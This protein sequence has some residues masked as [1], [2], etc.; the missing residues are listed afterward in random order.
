MCARFTL[1]A[2]P[3]LLAERFNLLQIPQLVAR[4]NIAPSQLL[5]V[6]GTK[7]GS[8]AR[9]LAMFKW[10][11]IPNWAQDDK[12]MRPVNARSESIAGSVMFG[13]SFRKRRCIVPADGFYEWRTEGKRKLPVHFRLM[14]GSPFAFAGIGD[15]WKGPSGSV[16]TYAIL[17]TKPN[18]LTATVH[19]RMPV[20]LAREDEAAWLDP[21]L[22]DATKLLPLLR[23]FPAA[24]MEAVAANP[25]MN[26]PQ[27]EG[28]GCLTLAS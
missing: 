11:F 17:T 28:P 26:R 12:G 14:D 25:A 10:G 24:E 8:Q 22:D 20:I 27:F 5:P 16:F 4:Y 15:V 7:A 18:E 13:E 9:G 19:D 21:G 23:S 3:D 1:R 6:V 2:P